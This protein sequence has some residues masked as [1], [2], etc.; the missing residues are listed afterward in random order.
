MLH[1]DRF[2]PSDTASELAF[3]LAYGLAK[4]AYIYE[5]EI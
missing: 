2:F 5:G 4:R 1:S 3:D